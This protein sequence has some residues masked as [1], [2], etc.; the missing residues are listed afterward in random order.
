MTHKKKKKKTSG[1]AESKISETLIRFAEPLMDFFGPDIPPDTI[2]EM[3]LIAIT[4]W[5]AVVFDQLG[6]GSHFIHDIKDRMSTPDMFLMR[7]LI[8]VLI[9]QKR[10]RFAEDFRMISH[11]EIIFNSDGSWLV[12]VEARSA[13][14]R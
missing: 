7:G 9:E 14:E 3:F 11:H 13:F 2:R 6:R 10:S 8:D 1:K 4:V 12:R 5:N